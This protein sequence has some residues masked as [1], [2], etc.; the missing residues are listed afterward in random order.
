MTTLTQ[1]CGVCAGVPSDLYAGVD[2]TGYGVVGILWR[3]W[4]YKRLLVPELCVSNDPQSLK[5]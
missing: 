5:I 3:L 1:D 4:H 2:L